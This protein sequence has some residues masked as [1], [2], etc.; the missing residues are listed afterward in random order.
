MVPVPTRQR[1]I[2]LGVKNSDVS[3]GTIVAVSIARPKKGT[4]YYFVLE[5]ERV[6]EEPPGE[7]RIKTLDTARGLV[8]ITE[9]VDRPDQW[10]ASTGFIL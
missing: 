2:N 8:E 3:V 4:S 1:A 10:F 9:T 5:V 6:G 7:L